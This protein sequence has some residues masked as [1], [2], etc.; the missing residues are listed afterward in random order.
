[1]SRRF[2]YYGLVWAILFVLFNIICFAVPAE[3]AGMSKYGGAFWTGYIFISIA[4]I[5]QLV[6]AYIALKA[7]NLT[8]LLYNIPLIG[9]SYAC[10]ILTLIFGVICM[11]VP[12]FPDWVGI[13]ICLVIFAFAA[14]AVIMAKAVSDIAGKIDDRDKP[15]AQFIKT[16]TADAQCLVAYAKTNEAKA[17]CRKVYEALRY[18]DPVSNGKLSSIEGQIRDKYDAFSKLVKAGD[19]DGS[20]MLS[21]AADELAAMINDRNKKCKVMK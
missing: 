21:E 14:V 6:C 9:I 12:G 20:E 7:D 1:M 5:G 18:S 11:A 4:F 15:D 19:G 17:A 13:V 10:L 2:K 8:K 3:A 16:I